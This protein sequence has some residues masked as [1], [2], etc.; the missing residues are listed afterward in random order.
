MP[1]VSTSDRADF[2]LAIDPCIPADGT[3]EEWEAYRDSLDESHLRLTGEPTR[4]EVRGFSVRERCWVRDRVSES[5]GDVALMA[6][7]YCRVGLCGYEEDRRPE[8]GLS[9]LTED[10]VFEV[11]GSIDAI[12][13][14]GMYLYG[15]NEVSQQLG[16]ESP[17]PPTEPTKTA[18]SEE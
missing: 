3:I 12:I 2:I 8:K 18:T 15:E 14:L 11:L 6:L 4:Y 16:K 7:S 10:K 13:H 9:L 5:K 17:S 1:L